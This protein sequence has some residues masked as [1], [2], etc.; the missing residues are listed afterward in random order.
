MKFMHLS[1]LHIGKRVNEYSMLEDQTYILKQIL[2]LVDEEKPEAVLIAGDIYDKSVP[3]G[4]AVML[5]DRFL[6]QLAKR[7]VP[8]FLI[9]GNHD[10]AERLA[11]GRE[12]L[13]DSDV[14]VS[15]VYEGKIQKITKTDQ[16]GRIHFYLF[17]F[18][19]PAVVKHFMPE[20]E[21][22]DYQSAM[23]AVVE[24]MDIDFSERNVFLVHQFLTGAEKSESEE[25]S[26]GGLDDISASVFDGI[27]YVALGHIHRP[28]S[29]SRDTVRYCG[30]P[31]KYSFSEAEHEKTV[32]FV[33]MKEKGKV[34]I[35]ERKLVPIR[36]M[37]KIKGS[38]LELTNPERYKNTRVED[39][40][41]ITLTDDEDIPEVMGK[42][43]CIYPNIMKLEY[44]NR[45]TRAAGIDDMPGMADDKTPLELFAEFYEKQNGMS[46]SDAQR[47]Y[48]SAL[49]EDIWED[50]L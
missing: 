50:S 16:Y 19:K 3:G 6:T 13:A 48:V 41:A 47:E 32:T 39:Y 31:L 25:V 18:L 17:P 27:D 4:D 35:T 28:Q 49:I 9:S 1:D 22:T 24:G 7:K 29:V 45:R 10:S 26:V 15:E 8:V 20:K 34:E 33:T 46:M 5:F 14:Y 23:E 21:I 42:L 12:L 30:T 2:H 36:D 11:F 38:Y 40:L 37:R 43:S 44:D